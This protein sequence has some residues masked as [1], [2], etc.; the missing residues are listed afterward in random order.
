MKQKINV[1][2]LTIVSISIFACAKVEVIENLETKEGIAK[3]VDTVKIVETTEVMIETSKGLSEKASDNV[4]I[5]AFGTVELEILEVERKA[6]DLN[7]KLDNAMNQ[8]DMN[9][10]S[11]ELYKLWD[12][13]LND[14]WNR[15]KE[16][17]DKTSMQQLVEDEKAWIKDKEKKIKEAGLAYE[18][19]SMQLLEENIVGASLTRERVYFLANVLARLLSE[20]EVLDRVER[21][22]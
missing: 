9:E 22:G 2:L 1:L 20:S 7:T 16:K 8:L 12:K 5:L 6:K 21:N 10:I 19:G 14:L 11:S 17:N 18:G 15:I 3:N 4:E 13:E